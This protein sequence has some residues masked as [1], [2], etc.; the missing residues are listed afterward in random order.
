MCHVLR[1]KICSSKK[2]YKVELNNAPVMQYDEMADVEVEQ[3]LLDNVNNNGDPAEI[4]QR[5]AKKKPKRI[6]VRPYPPALI[7]RISNEGKELAK[8]NGRRMTTRI[9][10]D[11]Y[12]SA[13]LSATS[14]DR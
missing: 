4:V 10:L 12:P 7:I 8:S 14:V 13:G 1:N 9:I 2:A 6:G 11:K 5:P 3:L